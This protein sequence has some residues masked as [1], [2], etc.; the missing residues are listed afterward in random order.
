M[1]QSASTTDS[2]EDSQSSM[3]PRHILVAEDEAIL[4]RG[5]VSELSS[6]GYEVIGPASNGRAAVELARK[7]DVDIAVLDIRMPEM[8]GLEAAKILYDEM[9]IPSI[10]VSAYSDHEYVAEATTLGVYGYLLKPVSLDDLKVAIPVAWGR[11]R[12]RA[13]LED[14]VADLHQK[15]E[16]RKV[17]EKAK[18]LLMKHLNLSEEDAMRKLQK[19]AR[20]SRRPMADLAK[21]I[22]DAQDVMGEDLFK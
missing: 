4:A 3:G 5:L 9:D 12:E 20:D 7:G 10:I 19:Q 13:I 14:S 2:Q 11:F 22:L 18:G 15:L 16:N 1:S 17:I 21:S 6:L 8:T